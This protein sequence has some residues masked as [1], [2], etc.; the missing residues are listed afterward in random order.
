LGYGSRHAWH[1][2]GGNQVYCWSNPIHFTY[3]EVSTI[4]NQ[5]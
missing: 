2:L 3:D 4:D 5:N 1:Y